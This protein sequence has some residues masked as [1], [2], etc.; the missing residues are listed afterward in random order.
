MTPTQRTQPTHVPTLRFPE[1]EGEWED[2][3]FD[4]IYSFKVTNSFSRELLNYDTGT[5]KNIHYGDIHTKF[6]ANFDITKE[7]VPYINLSVNLVKISEDNYCKE[8]DIIFADASEDL[9]DVGKAIEIVYLNENKLLSGLHTILARPQIDKI[10]SGF[11]GYLFQS[12]G[13]R[14]Q[15]QHES[16]GSKVLSI[17]A[18]RLAKIKL[19]IPTLAEQEKITKFLT[20]IDA[21][22]E[23]LSKQKVLLEEYKKGVMQAIF[24]DSVDATERRSDGA[25]DKD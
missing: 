6:R 13:M 17:S 11:G 25:T 16:Q 10:F 15:I 2:I 23:L 4:K 24:A 19:I 20:A 18:K 22:I 21:K 9:K 5:V 1:F 3:Q 7:H 14:N 12:N 8:G